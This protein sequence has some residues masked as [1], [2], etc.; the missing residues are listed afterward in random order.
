MGRVCAPMAHISKLLCW[1]TQARSLGSNQKPPIAVGESISATAKI[2]CDRQLG[3]PKSQVLVWESILAIFK[4]K[5]EGL[6]VTS[7]IGVNK[8]NDGQTSSDCGG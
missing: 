6:T 8:H 3:S 7:I 4:V 5:C 2:E 1:K